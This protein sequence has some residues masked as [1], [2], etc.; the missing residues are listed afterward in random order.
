MSL[1]VD[2]IDLPS[3][4][5]SKFDELSDWV[6]ACLGDD[7]QIVVC[8]YVADSKNRWNRLRE[9]LRRRP[10]TIL[11]FFEHG[12]S[13]DAHDRVREA[14][15]ACTELRYVL[16]AVRVESRGWELSDIFVREGSIVPDILTLA[17]VDQTVF[18]SQ[19]E[20][21][22]ATRSRELSEQEHDELVTAMLAL[23]G[24]LESDQQRERGRLV[25]LL[26]A[27]SG[28]GADRIAVKTVPSSK[29]LGNRI[30]EALARNPALLIVVCPEMLEGGVLEEAEQWPAIGFATMVLVLC[31]EEVDVVVRGSEPLAEKLRRIL[32]KQDDTSVAPYPASD[33]REEFG[34]WQAW[35]YEDWNRALVDYV[36]SG[37]ENDAPVERLAATPEELAEIVGSSADM[38][39]DV[40][41]AFV[42]ACVDQMPYGVASFCGFCNDYQGGRG[43]SQKPWSVDSDSSPHFFGMLW[44]TCL[45]VYGYPDSRGGFFDRLWA[46]TGKCDHIKCLPDLWHAMRDWTCG[47]RARGGRTRELI[48]PPEDDFRT[49]IG[50]SH[51]LAFPHALDRRTLAAVLVD[52]ELVGFEP[53][54][55]P[56][57]KTLRRHRDRFS[58][59]FR[60]DLDNFVSKFIEGRLDV[61]DSAFWRAVR[62]EALEPSATGR[63]RRR[64]RTTILALFDDDG[65]LP[66][67]GCAAD[68]AAPPDVE[69]LPL[70]NPIGGFHHYA[71]ER[72]AG[73]DGVIE[74]MLGSQMMLGPGPRALVKQGVLVFQEDQS[75]EYFLVSG[76]EINGA[77]VALVRDELVQRFLDTF[78]GTAHPFRVPGWSEITGCAVR[79][80]D[81]LPPGLEHV[82][83]L[84]R[85]MTPP[86]LRLV[87]GI[88]VSGGYMGF[89]GFLPRVRAPGA[90]SVSVE[91][92]DETMPCV[93]DDDEWVLPTRI[94]ESLPIEVRLEARWD[95]LRGDRRSE[96]RL[97]FLPS[98]IFE[99]YKPL[100]AGHFFVESCRPGQMDIEGGAPIP[101]GITAESPA[102]SYDLIEW[103]P[104]ARYLGAGEGEMSLS[105]RPGFDWLVV[106]P[107]KNPELL[108]FVGDPDAPTS[109][110]DAQSPNKGDRR[111]WK[112]PLTRSHAVMVRESGGRYRPVEEFPRVLEMLASYRS[113][114]PGE[115]A[116]ECTPTNLD[117]VAHEPPGRTASAKKT[118]AFEDAVAALSARRSGLRYRTVQALFASLTGTKD[119][120]LHHELIRAWA[121]SGAVDVVRHQSYSVTKIVGRPPRFVGIR[122][123]PEVEA[124]LLG[125]T[126]SG[127]M[128]RV[129]SQAEEARLRV[130]EV[131]PGNPW[132][133][134]VIRVRGPVGDIDRLASGL[135]LHPTEWLAWHGAEEV[136]EHLD[137]SIEHQGL[138]RDRPPKGFTPKKTWSFE[139]SVFRFGVED[140]VTGV[141]VQQWVHAEQ[142]SIYVV[143]RD[144]VPDLWTYIRNWALLHAYDVSGR[145]PFSLD[146]TG[147]VRAEGRTPVH[148]P[149]ALG[150]LC[151]IVGEGVPG[152]TWERNGDVGGYCYPFGRRAT[153]VVKKVI[154][155]GWLQRGED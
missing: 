146:P 87:G 31:G 52:A 29:N 27:A 63:R 112:S 16:I 85:T 145:A 3:R 67:L 103:E 71:Q 101:L 72:G 139:E 117:T 92:D 57:L 38:A 123:G 99:S 104:S 33:R 64:N 125:L 102:S 90:A 79:P 135:A 155:V 148:L 28:H 95:G 73:L 49:T 77:D 24:E 55:N 144:G 97:R 124:S 105:R 111:H 136:P 37:A 74:A 21:P 115:Q 122:R 70:D 18:E 12:S 69:K 152:P 41:R 10:V 51:F 119:Y 34:P 8:K 151:T 89:P 26:S 93:L 5:S 127:L 91:A 129:R 131:R 86:S 68:W 46:L 42:A 106:G 100:G 140:D 59:L 128:A 82:L 116:E 132:Q 2:E 75:Q 6:R 96:R 48:L 58:A 7:D 13:D 32:E 44:L 108:L 4:S 25:E 147:W 22:A 47:K 130:L 153:E 110:R 141:A 15:A 43:R 137:V 138:W 83:Q 88:K 20:P 80:L 149:L 17:P 126:T 114:R 60:E 19:S 134:P 50:F 11:L 133:A 14:A 142:C 1:L 56:V 30:G 81:E 107:K 98:P 45:V 121:D 120:A 78:G 40:T 39:A 154:P 54:I 61:R 53:P 113:L 23:S 109:P 65:L 76:H 118:R 62:Q 36:F 150:R 35:S 94:A 84:E 66:I 9:A 143:L